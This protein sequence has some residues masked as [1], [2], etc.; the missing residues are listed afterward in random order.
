MLFNT[1]TTNTWQNDLTPPSNPSSQ[2]TTQ[3]VYSPGSQAAIIYKCLSA[4]TKLCD[5][6]GIK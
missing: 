6:L 4:V 2:L 5:S 1:Y 3:I